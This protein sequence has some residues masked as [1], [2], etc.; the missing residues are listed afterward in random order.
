MVLK[1]LLLILWIG[2]VQPTNSASLEPPSSTSDRIDLMTVQNVTFYRY[3]YTTGSQKRLRFNCNY[4]YGNQIACPE[5]LTKILCTN[6]DYLK[7][8]RVNA[9]RLNWSC[10]PDE[11][12]NF[13]F[14][15]EE[16]AFDV[17]CEEVNRTISE[18]YVV[19][20]SCSVTFTLNYR[21]FLTFLLY[22]FAYLA[23]FVGGTMLV[24]LI[25]FLSKRCRGDYDNLSDTSSV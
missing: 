4:V 5:K 23:T 8:D 19:R 7:L 22:L 12:L 25:S 14:Y 9:T 15:I 20:G 13:P 16:N 24:L 11:L 10:K 21:W 6:N 1:F 18:R 17:Q 3:E 2:Y